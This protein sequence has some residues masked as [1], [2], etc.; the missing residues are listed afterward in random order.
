MPPHHLA[1]VIPRQRLT[2]SSHQLPPEAQFHF[3]VHEGVE[4]HLLQI[5]HLPHQMQLSSSCPATPDSRTDLAP[6]VAPGFELP[7]N[8][9]PTSEGQPVPAHLQ[10]ALLEQ[11]NRWEVR[12]VLVALA[13][14]GADL[15]L[16]LEH[17]KFVEP[18]H[19]VPPS[20]HDEGRSQAPSMTVSLDPPA[21]W[22]SEMRN[23][24]A[25]PQSLQP[26]PSTPG[27][28]L[29]EGPL[30]GLEVCQPL[31]FIFADPHQLTLFVAPPLR[32]GHPVVDLLPR[33]QGAPLPFLPPQI[34]VFSKST[35]TWRSWAHNLCRANWKKQHLTH[36]AFLEPKSNDAGCSSRFVLSKTWLCSPA[37]SIALRT[38]KTPVKNENA[39]LGLQ[40]KADEKSQT[41]LPIA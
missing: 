40:Q 21:S 33:S 22:T 27:T 23:P 36:D 14:D 5:D 25:L 24:S 8:H 38:E 13:L 11:H 32:S 9:S 30:V 37:V 34:F 16:V 6:A 15:V 31:H 26:A 19:V 41:A 29:V 4:N 2:W 10:A 7:L 35:S 17:D 20:P 3:L 39:R 12:E 28:G 18:H 1:S